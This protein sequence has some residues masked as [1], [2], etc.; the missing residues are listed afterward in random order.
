MFIEIARDCLH[1]SGK[2]TVEKGVLSCVHDAYGK[3]VSIKQNGVSNG[4]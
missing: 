4:I 1:S 3:K 2:F